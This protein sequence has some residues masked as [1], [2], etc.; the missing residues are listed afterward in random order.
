MDW[1]LYRILSTTT[2]ES[3]TSVITSL[4]PS[5]G[6]LLASIRY[7]TLGRNDAVDV[8][9]SLMSKSPELITGDLPSWIAFHTLDRMF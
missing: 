4:K 6:K 9:K 1:T 5:D 2:T 7:W 8:L 3:F